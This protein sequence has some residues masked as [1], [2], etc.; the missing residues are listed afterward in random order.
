MSANGAGRENM[1]TPLRPEAR[2]A[3]TEAALKI[4]RAV[5]YENAGTVEFIVEG[6][7]RADNFYFMEMNTRLQVEHPV[8]EA[9]TGVD[10]VE[11]QLRIA[12]GEKLP[13]RQD[14]IPLNGCAVEARLCAED[15]SEDFRPSVG[16][17]NAF[18]HPRGVR[19]DSGFDAGDKVPPDYDSLI[20]KFISHRPRRADALTALNA[21][22]RGAPIGG[23]A[24]NAAFLCRVLVYPAFF[25]ADVQE[26]DLE[27]GF[28]AKH[29]DVLSR[30]AH[31]TRDAAIA[32]AAL[33]LCDALE[34]AQA[35]SSHRVSF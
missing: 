23:I 14:Q 26:G 5:E 12:A 7:P 10:L 33:R 34:N 25:H 16:R 1:T 32:A 28:L 29:M 8:T 6:A 22:I 31:I 13:L 27:T 19:E 4:A 18:D 24:T 35:K 11:W 30:P 15:P 21:G 20:A 3:M 2:A 9:I 17:I